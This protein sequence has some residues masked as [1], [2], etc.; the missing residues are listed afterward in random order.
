MTDNSLDA[1]SMLNY[2]CI[3]ASDYERLK[4][5]KEWDFEDKQIFICPDKFWYELPKILKS[6]ND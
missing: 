4:D 5:S 3:K 1:I 6:K 2:T